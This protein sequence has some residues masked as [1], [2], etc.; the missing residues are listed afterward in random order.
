MRGISIK[1]KIIFKIFET[2]S[3]KYIFEI[4]QTNEIYFRIIRCG[5]FQ[6]HFWHSEP[7]IEDIADLNLPETAWHALVVVRQLIFQWIE[8]TRPAYF[9]FS[10]TNRRRQ[11]IYRYLIAKHI[12]CLSLPYEFFEEGLHF[13]FVRLGDR[14]GEFAN[15]NYR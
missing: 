12:H 7:A 4:S 11:R 3:Q 5:S 14:N 8:R 15:G 1:E 9:T 2:K 6:S 13:S 10:A